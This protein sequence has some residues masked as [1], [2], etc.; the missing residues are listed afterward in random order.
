MA[1]LVKPPLRINERW[2][3]LSENDAAVKWG[4]S[5]PTKKEPVV[6]ETVIAKEK[7]QRKKRVVR[8]K[9]KQKSFR[10][11]N[12]EQLKEL[13]TFYSVPEASIINFALGE[14]VLAKL[15]KGF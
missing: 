7:P 4:G 11:G 8:K 12:L 6:T 2:N 10:I 9:T 15:K 14:L 13:A 1:K 3:E 5:A